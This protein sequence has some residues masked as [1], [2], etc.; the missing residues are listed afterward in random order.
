MK[1]RYVFV[2]LGLFF[3]TATASADSLFG[4]QLL[5]KEA[6]Q[7]LTK[8]DWATFHQLLPQLE[9]YPLYYY[10]RYRYLRNDLKTVSYGELQDFLQR[11]GDT[12]FGDQLRQAW[13]LQL[14]KQG[15]WGT[16]MEVYT[17]QKS[18]ALQCYYAQ[19]RLMTTY[20]VDFVMQDI[21]KLWLVGK[22]QP[23]ACDYVFERFYNSHLMSEQ[24]IWI[25]IHLAMQNGKTSLADA[26]A[27][28]LDAN[29]QLWFSQWMTMHERPQATLDTFAMADSHIARLIVLHGIRRIA[30]KNFDDAAF[31]WDKFQ[32]RYAFSV[33]QIGEMQRD[34]AFACNKQDH[35]FAMRQLTKVNKEFIDP[36]FN[37]IRLNLA[38]RE[39]NWQAL[40]D[41]IT[42]LPEQQKTSLKWRYW[43]SRA[44]EKLGKASAARKE[45]GK[46]ANEQDYYGFLAADQID[47]T[48]QIENRAPAFTQAEQSA[49]LANTPLM[50]VYEFYQV[51]MPKNGWREWQHTIEQLSPRQQELAATIASQWGWHSKAFKTAAQA[52]AY[53]NLSVRFPLP[54][55]E[56]LEEGAN[57]QALNPAWVY[58]IVRQES[59]FQQHARSRAGALG[60][61]Q[62]MPATG[63][64]V[65]RK[66]GIRLSSRQDM[67][68]IDTNIMLGTAYL[69]E[70]LDRF[71][72]NY[73]LATAA[74]NAGPSRAQ[75]WS[76]AYTCLP[77]DIW[78][79]L[80]PFKETR[81]YV[82][83]VLF[84][85][86]IFEERLGREVR[87]LR[88]A[89]APLNQLCG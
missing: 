71:D 40:A 78:I 47:A 51:G 11:Y 30:D 7:A 9:A 63:R 2:C 8:R 6:N 55:R 82:K 83:R 84:Y 10:L 32:L 73:V 24:L 23:N 87:P 16:F 39:Q 35:P 66:L 14:A 17:P 44:L 42:E 81:K 41:F 45:Y 4:E 77:A 50:K 12:Y 28:R 19:A 27:K 57:A 85:T 21:K 54:F 59:A 43:Y 22:S 56:N 33:Q 13:L 88:V 62:L 65:A 29:G 89:L 3:L 69:R 36:E 48:Y 25:R 80:I 58:G 72:G 1:L 49:L 18:T 26:L 76:Q 52:G 64:H 75:K 86:A 61:M 68:D 46:L 15:D 34:L 70:V 5:F 20:D 74:Y 31:Y 67:L 53:Q 79:E 60:L 38:L 37:E